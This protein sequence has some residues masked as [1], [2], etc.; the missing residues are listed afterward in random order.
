[1]A[2]VFVN[3]RG[4]GWTRIDVPTDMADARNHAAGGTFEM[5]SHVGHSDVEGL[6]YA[7][8]LSGKDVYAV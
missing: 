4:D 3:L 6:P 7:S 8:C 2:L 5:A 1:M